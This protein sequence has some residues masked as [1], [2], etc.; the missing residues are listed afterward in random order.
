MMLS[1]L[2]ILSACAGSW[3]NPDL[4]PAQAS[5]DE[6]DCRRESEADMGPQPYT[7]PGTGTQDSPMQMV[8]RS[9]ARHEFAGLV[10]DC[11]ERKGYRRD[12]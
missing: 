2:P 10:S 3:H 4:P 5:A 7:S 12:K 1:V 6:R 11:M 8:D 9:E